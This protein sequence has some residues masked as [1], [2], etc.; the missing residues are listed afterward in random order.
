MMAASHCQSLPQLLPQATGSDRSEKGITSPGVLMAAFWAPHLV[1]SAR[2]RE[3]VVI[4]EGG[5][6]EWEM[7]CAPWRSAPLKSSLM[8]VGN[9]RSQGLE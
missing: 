5:G 8:W 4:A 2:E 9:S 7:P 6:H 1:R 3:R